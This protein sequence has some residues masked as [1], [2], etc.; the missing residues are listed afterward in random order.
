MPSTT[1]KLDDGLVT[2]VS[3][4]KGDESISA[5]V[6]SLIEKEYRERLL[7]RA[8]AD[9][10]RFLEEHPAEREAMEVWEDAP[11]AGEIEPRKP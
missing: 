11:L 1:V 3:E 5:Y 8:A 4:I 2:K 10:G 9:Y 7:R 6:R